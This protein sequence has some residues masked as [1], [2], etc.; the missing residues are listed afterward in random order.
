MFATAWRLLLR[1]AGLADPAIRSAVAVNGG[2]RV[3]V[4]GE[5]GGGRPRIRDGRWRSYA[6]STVLVV[7]T[8]IGA[9]LIERLTGLDDLAILFVPAILYSAA[10]WGLGPSLWAS[11][12][13]VVGYNFF[14]LEPRY[15]LAIETL[16]ELFAS[17]I[18]AAIAVVTSDLATKLRRQAADAERREQ[19]VALLYDLSRALSRIDE[20]NDIA[21]LLAERM[22]LCLNGPVSL[23][24]AERPGTRPLLLASS[25]SMPG[26]SAADLPPLWQPAEHGEPYLAA[27]GARGLCPLLLD[28]KLIGAILVPPEPLRPR[29]DPEMHALLLALADLAN[30]AL[31]RLLLGRELDSTRRAA[32]SE[33]LRSALLNSVSHDLRTPLAAITGTATTLLAG[34]ERLTEAARRTLLE[35]LHEEAFRLDRFVGNLLD[36]TRLQAGALTP[37]FDWVD[38]SEIVAA[39]LRHLRT[40]LARV[41]VE[42]DI[43]DG[44]PMLR[45]DE[46][47]TQHMLVNLI[48]NAVKYSPPGG[49]VRIT[50]RS[51]G[52]QVVITV[53]DQGPGVA[54]EQRDVIFEPFHSAV[55]GD[56][57][58]AGTGLGL[59]ITKTFATAQG[60][61]IVVG[62]SALGGARFA[63][64]F[65]VPDD[66][67]TEEAHAGPHA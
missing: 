14:F 15:S 10:R 40:A 1:H 36:L 55:G 6:L 42:R 24:L 51:E 19:R 26:D 33:R 48:D 31:I 13:S 61:S 3:P 9:V 35:A 27:G 67:P 53:E 16:D 65:A 58:R 59:M 21:R 52:A 50:A 12:A 4:T 66:A 63:V 37:K 7:G 5:P 8:I 41:R 29:G 46:V 57:R 28:G 62:R 11:L 56:R 20:L 54:P 47:L 60:G 22:A 64:A 2:D 49:T 23:W 18:F 38:L 43:A 34:E 44:L 39:A 17:A 30:A 32:E 25:E 45:L